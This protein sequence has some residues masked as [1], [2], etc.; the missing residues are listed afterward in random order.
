M[1]PPRR[2]SPLCSQPTDTRATPPQMSPGPGTC[3][4]PLGKLPWPQCCHPPHSI[5]LGLS[6]FPTPHSHFPSVP[7]VSKTPRHT[8][9]CQGTELGTLWHLGPAVRQQSVH[10]WDPVSHQHNMCA[11]HARA[12]PHLRLQKHHEAQGHS[13]WE[14]RLWA[15][16][17]PSSKHLSRVVPLPPP[18][19]PAIFGAAT[20]CRA[21]EQAVQ[22][23]SVSLA[24]ALNFRLWAPRKLPEPMPH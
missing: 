11:R 13:H 18:A 24:P 5:L 10:P 9:E 21:A 4:D 1:R 17:H 15:P 2:C 12:T 22:R 3:P 6:S 7:Q 20:K 14:P 8:T 16:Q 19:A 23:P